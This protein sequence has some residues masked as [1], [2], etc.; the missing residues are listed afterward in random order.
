MAI[1]HGENLMSTFLTLRLKRF[2]PI[3]LLALVAAVL[4]APAT[5]NAT[6]Y[7]V[8]LTQQGNNVVATGSGA[9]DLTGFQFFS[10][11]GGLGFSA[12][13]DPTLPGV[14]LGSQGIAIDYYLGTTSGPPSFGSGAPIGDTTGIG[15]PIGFGPGQLAVPKGYSSGTFLSNSGAWDN[16]SFASLGV[17]PG[18]YTWTWGTNAEQSFTLIIGNPVG[19]P[20]P[21]ALGMFG[22]GVLLVGAFVGLRR[23]VG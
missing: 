16:A 12:W 2:V 11:E 4:L 19:V 13:L 6:P 21:A 8:K 18:T 20:E 14:E 5:A 22:F 1:S 15:D 3:G 7:V 23:R 17:T 9:F 10:Q